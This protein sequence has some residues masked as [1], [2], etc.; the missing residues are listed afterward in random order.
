MTVG[1]D[2][3]INGGGAPNSSPIL[4]KA[5]NK[6]GEIVFQANVVS[7]SDGTFYYTTAIEVTGELTVVASMNNLEASSTS[8]VM[9]ND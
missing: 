2:I 6:E 4:I 7:S 1:N 8:L 3:E 9:E 5:L